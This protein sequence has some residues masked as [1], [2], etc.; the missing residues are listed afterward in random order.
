MVYDCFTFFNE[1]D[2][3]ELRLHELSDSVDY[4]VLV[5]ATHT[6][7]NQPKPLYFDENKGRFYE[8]LPKIIHIIVD[9]FP[10]DPENRWILENYQRNAIMQGLRNCNPYDSIIISDIDEIVRADSVNKYKNRPGIKFFMQEMFYYYLN[11]KAIGITWKPV[12]MVFFKDLISP[13]W[14]RSYPIPLGRPSSSEIKRAN[15]KHRL[16]KLIGLNIYIKNGGWHFSYLGGANKILTKIK[17]FAHEEYHDT[18]T[19]SDDIQS[20]INNSEDLFGREDMKLEFTEI[21]NSFPRYLR[22]NIERFS[23]MIKSPNQ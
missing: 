4:F 9:D 23:F 5:E 15:L 22:E 3:L 6:H 20:L 17:S 1:L 13:Q 7:S 11:C 14:L 12:K 19:N 18:F 21:D 2:L 16:R 8:F 10:K